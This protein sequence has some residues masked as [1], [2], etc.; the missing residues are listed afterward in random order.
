MKNNFGNKSCK[1]IVENICPYCNEHLFMNK[2]SFAN[3]IRWCKKNP[4]YEEIL[5]S[6]KKNVSKSLHQ[7][8]IDKN[9]E[10]KEFKVKCRN[11]GKEFIVIEQENKF[12]VKEYYYCSSFCSHAH[13]KYIDNI[14]DKISNGFKIKSEKYKEYYYNRFNKEYIFEKE[15]ICPICNKIFFNKRRKYCSDECIKKKKLYDKLPKILN[16]NDS[17]KL[18]EIKKLYKSECSFKFSLNNFPKEFNFK[19]V[20]EYGWYKAKNKG[21]NLYGVSRDHKYSCNEAFKNL[22]DPYLISHPANCQLLIH[23]DNISKLDKC[24]ITLKELKDNIYNWNLKYGE[25]PNKINYDIFEKLNIHFI[26]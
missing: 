4:K 14:S 22:I 18:L 10:F 16:L 7:Y 12:P 24:S 19:L 5:N 8:N 15:K 9:G 13:N 20:E 11:C 25:Y 26:K 1:E 23:N 21:N 6:T 17:E 3:H 2:R